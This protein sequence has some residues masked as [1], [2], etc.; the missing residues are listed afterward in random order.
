MGYCSAP[1]A[2]WLNGHCSTYINIGGIHMNGNQLPD[3]LPLEDF[4]ALPDTIPLIFRN[5]SSGSEAF[6]QAHNIR[7][8]TVLNGIYSIDYVHQDEADSITAEIGSDETG[9]FPI[10][11]GLLDQQNLRA[12]GILQVQRHPYLDLRGRGTLVG[13]IDTGIDYTKDAFR[14]E[15]GTSKIKY[16]WDQSIRGNAPEGYYFGTEYTEEEINDALR[17]GDPWASVPH[18]DTVGHGTFLASVAAG[19]GDGEYIGA[20]PE[21]E[22]IAVKMKR[23]GAFHYEQFLIPERQENAYLSSDL[24]LGVHYI[25]SKAEELGRPVVICIAIGSNLGGHSGFNPTEEYLT[26]VSGI[27]GVAVVCAAGNESQ[28]RHHTNGT[29]AGSGT[30]QNV[31]LAVG[32]MAEDIYLS[33]WNGASDRI[34]VS[35]T[36]P[37]G[38]IIPKIP[39]RPGASY[40]A[41]LI[42]E[43][44]RV[45]VEYHL[46][47]RVSGDQFTRIKIFNPTPGIWTITVHGEIVLQGA[48]HF[49]LPLT[50]FIDPDTMFLTPTPNFTIVVPASATGVIT[51]GAY[52]GNNNSLYYNS[53]W[54]PIRRPMMAPDFVAP[55]VDV[56]GMFPSGFGQMS[57]TSVAAAITAGACALMLQWG[58]VEDNET[59]LN[60]E[61]IKA[62][63]IRGCD[64]DM[65]TEYPNAQWGYG[66]LNLYN[67]MNVMRPL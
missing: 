51:C 13:F 23:A 1:T 10:V 40:S 3:Q 21:A 7:K 33:L 41:N 30:S 46:P 4:I 49:W 57:G 45:L 52:A 59:V 15:D 2:D 12:A 22:I 5:E 54:G 26:S 48:F 32:A 34:A 35:L 65:F 42:L 53:S 66:R 27:N 67:T 11:L 64:R 20:A 17:T 36:S 55:G 60:T 56:G 31:E 43:K 14:Y 61:R 62:Y 47:L 8:G 9:M 37:T 18:R 25:L 28:T 39:V 63:L 16:I 58:I 6:R 24:M 44:S 50:G 29:L 19:R 38:E